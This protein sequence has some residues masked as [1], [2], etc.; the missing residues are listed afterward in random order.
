MKQLKVIV[1]SYNVNNGYINVNFNQSIDINPYSSIA[2]DKISLQIL[3][4][5]SGTIVIQE[6]QTI[7]ITTQNRGARL[8]G[9]RSVILP[10][11][12][13]T[14]NQ[15][16][17][18]VPS[19]ANV[20][21]LPDIITT[22]NNLFNGI[23]IGTPLLTSNTPGASE[24]DYGLGFKWIGQLTT[25]NPPVYKVRLDSYQ[26]DFGTGSNARPFLTPP[27][28]FIL[29][30]PVDPGTG[31]VTTIAKTTSYLLGGAAG[32]KTT[33]VSGNYGIVDSIPIISGCF[34]GNIR[35]V[36]GD[37]NTTGSSFGYGLVRA[38]DS[39]TLPIIIYGFVFV[40][41]NVYVIDNSI[42]NYNNPIDKDYF[43]GDNVDGK[44]GTVN[45]Y[46]YTDNTEGNL[47]LC[48]ENPSGTIA[49]T[50]PVGAYTGFDL[51]IPY[52]M[53]VRGYN[54]MGMG[55]S[56]YFTNFR[57][58]HQP[59][60]QI[61]NNGLYYAIPPPQL[62]LTTNNSIVGATTPNRQIQ[63]D[64]TNSP[65][66][67]KG[68]GFGLNIIQGA[69]SD[70]STFS[71]TGPKGIDFSNYYDLGLQL[72]NINL[73]TYVGFTDGLKCGKNNTLAYFLAQRI[74]DSSDLFYYEQKQMMF[75]SVE[76]KEKLNISS[77]Q[78][79]VY[80]INTGLAVNLTSGS[81]NIFISNERE[82]RLD[83]FNKGSVQKRMLSNMHY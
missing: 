65:L 49:Y 74:S 53:A 52:Y 20:S 6:D 59:N 31:A 34:Q 9:V 1:N 83:E 56:N 5:A 43:I 54:G 25:D 37:I 23:L 21:A 8:S 7:N 12:Q 39:N 47:R 67:I 50:T 14:Y 19:N 57:A 33:S 28:Q 64:L 62:Y 15:T 29:T 70:N 58:F 44:E 24:L 72:L 41:N 18:F 11:G 13:Y 35:L 61:D 79:R 63:I 76:N 75:L 46:I 17:P 32:F 40:N 69:V 42:I 48:V 68:L 78:F 38:T 10:A 82:E 27:G 51:N 30:G 60:I 71:Y 81:F 3:P 22:L 73:E 4:N 77:L 45:V 2:L 16:T 26:D 80:D 36:L 55:N 66:L